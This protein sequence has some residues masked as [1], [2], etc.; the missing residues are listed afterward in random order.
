MRPDLQRL[1]RQAQ[2]IDR[3]RRRR[4]VVHEIQRLIDVVRLDDVDLTKLELRLTQM[5]DIAQRTRLQ[6]VHAN[7]PV[8]ATEQRLA[9]MRTEEAGPAG[10]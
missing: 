6:V 3:A 5:I 2:V 10:H 7:H 4:E 1:Q 8:P 9:Q